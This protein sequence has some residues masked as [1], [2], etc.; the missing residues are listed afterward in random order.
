[1]NPIGSSAL[2]AHVAVAGAHGSFL[3]LV[4]RWR[5]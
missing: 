2:P 3:E 1:M 4:P 5:P